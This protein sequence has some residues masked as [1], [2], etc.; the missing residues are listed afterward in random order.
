V[1]MAQARVRVRVRTVE[2]LVQAR[3]GPEALDG[4][5]LHR[6]GAYDLAGPVQ[7]EQPARWSDDRRGRAR[8]PPAWPGV[9][10]ARPAAGWV[11]ALAEQG[12]RRRDDGEEDCR[13]G[14]PHGNDQVRR[15]GT[16]AGDG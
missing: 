10:S 5:A 13:A 12:Q 11:L 7:R 3:G 8:A 4:L 6:R 15:D 2:E 16:A 1:P 9:P 14:D